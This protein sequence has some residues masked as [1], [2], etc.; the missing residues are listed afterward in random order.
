MTKTLIILNPASGRGR[1]ER[2]WDLIE[3]QLRLAGMQ[4]QVARTHQSLH[5]VQLAWEAPLQ[6]YDRVVAAGGDGLVHEVINGLVRASGDGETLPLGIIPLGNGNDFI[7]M[8]PPEC[9]IGENRDD[10]RPA[11]TRL[12]RG[13]TALFDLGRIEGDGPAPGH[14]YPDYFHNVMDVGLGA[15][16]ARNTR[17]AP[18]MLHGMP[19]YVYSLMGVLFHYSIPHL[20]VQVDD[21]KFEQPSTITAVA[22]G[23]CF[24]GGFWIAPDASARDGL[25]DVAV[26]DGLGPFHV[27]S[28]LPR[29]MKGTHVNL[30]IVKMLRAKR[31]VI[32]SEEPLIAEADGEPAF[33]EAHHLEIEMLPGKLKMI[34]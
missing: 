22:N 19:M 17:G 30:P 26:S 29:V 11:V 16:V 27:L 7:K 23:R 32:D 9:K 25:F 1:A 8:L 34:V 28:L 12:V 31:V 21:A 6:G 14:A 10:W 18:R 3:E 15:Q 5:A 24:A 33:F 20:R 4:Y 13:E 2:T